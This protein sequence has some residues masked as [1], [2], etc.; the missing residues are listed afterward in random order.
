M[1]A[2]TDIDRAKD[3]QILARIAPGPGATDRFP[4]SNPATGDQIAEVADMG[5]EDARQAIARAAAALPA[6]AAK[7]ARERA[8]I[9]RRWHDLILANQEAL[10]VLLTREQGKPLIEAM[11]EVAYGASFVEWFAEEGKRAYGDII[12]TNAA[13]RRLLVLRQPVGVVGAITPWNFPVGMVTRKVA[14]ALAAGC[15]IVLKPAEDTPLCA[16]ALAQLARDA[17]IPDGVLEVVTAVRAEPIA[18]VLTDSPD[19]RKLSFTGSTRVGK[20]LM[21]QC[22]DTVKKLSLELGGN[23]PFIVFD[24]A[25]L[26]A[27]VTGAIQSKFRNAGQTCVCANRLFVQAGVAE[28]F[29]ARFAAA[30]EALSVGDGMETGTAIGPLINA[31]ATA[32]VDGLV[33]DAVSKGA[34]CTLGGGAHD[35]GGNFYAPTILTGVDRSMEI[36]DA[37]IF[38][39]VAPILTF[40]TEDEVIARAN[41]TPYGLAAYFWTRDLG[42]A[43]RVAEQLEY[44]MIGLNEGF[45]SSE[46]APFGGVK[47]S[48]IGREGS[49]YGLDEFL[50]LKY[51][52][53]GGLSA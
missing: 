12:P 29:A 38:G 28:E 1:N 36:A 9:L 37:E 43:W 7:T 16:L 42:R 5:A 25:D 13:G 2:M 18:R 20:L 27:A 4:V 45:I 15:T 14:P 49:K 21:A 11:G 47:E 3:A 48:G 51:F 41:D 50:E 23:A 39:P 46:A 31:A 53:M 10:A 6:W 8:A 24:D 19:V 34:R 32:K 26:D 44:G 30:V 17:G 35:L 22:A 52:T 40:E 33:R